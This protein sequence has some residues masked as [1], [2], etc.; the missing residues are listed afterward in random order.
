MKA[1]TYKHYGPPDVLQLADIEQPIP[2]EDE[3]LIKVHAA[4]VNAYDWHLL[5]AK[6][7][8]ARF[9]A[10]LLKPRNPI[11]GA[12]F[13]GTVEAVGS[14]IQQYHPGDEVYGCRQGS[15]AEYLCS[16]EERIAM[17]PKN[18]SFE[19]AATVPMAALTALQALRDLGRI[20]SGQNVL[21][22]GAGG[23]IG[24]F[25]VQ[26]AKSFDAEVTAVCSTQNAAMVCSIGAD[27][28]IDY[29][30]EDFTRSSQRYD[31]ILGANGYH[32]L[33]AYKRALNPGGIYVMSG[34]TNAQMFQSIL[35][36]L[37]SFR[38]DKKFK[39]AAAKIV[40]KDLVYIKELLEAGKVVPVIDRKYLL[41]DVPDAIRYLEEGHAQGKVVI[42]VRDR[43]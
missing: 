8:L 35:E 18:L 1:I 5:R 10:G 36:P 41:R 42:T 16:R 37:A 13:A 4:S 27:H 22:N 14:H 15:F 28:V 25:A 11:L 6:P 17:K 30:K 7:F 33:F 19:Q 38:T 9:M 23:G 29:T 34:G 20:R 2:K 39:G 32:S 40:H 12:D 26:I 43:E 31:L 3:V 21:I 24:T